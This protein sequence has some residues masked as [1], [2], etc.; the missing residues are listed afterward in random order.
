MFFIKIFSSSFLNHQFCNRCMH[1][2]KNSVPRKLVSF[3]DTKC[4]NHS[5]FEKLHQ[6]LACVV[7]AMYDNFK[8]WQWEWLTM[9][10]QTYV[11]FLST[12]EPTF[13]N[14]S[15]TKIVI[16]KKTWCSSFLFYLYSFIIRK[17]SYSM[18]ICFS[19]SFF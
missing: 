2:L 7:Y 12:C 16:K 11:I 18:S 4:Y 14:Y 17:H 19:V 15:A 8:A 10:K 5:Y 3:K 13:K 6:S 1:R 9:D